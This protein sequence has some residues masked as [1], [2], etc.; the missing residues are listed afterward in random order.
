MFSL[1]EPRLFQGLEFENTVYVTAIYFKNVYYLQYFATPLN[2]VSAVLSS[3]FQF[4][5][6][7]LISAGLSSLA[8]FFSTFFAFL[9]E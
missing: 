5:Y 6:R 3:S 2:N 4:F 8:F 9:L 7:F 1:L